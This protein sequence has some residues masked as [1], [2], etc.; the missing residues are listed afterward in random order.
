MPSSQNR[1]RHTA[2]LCCTCIML[3]FKPA[4]VRTQETNIIPLHN[5]DTINLGT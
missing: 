5:A 4:V 3:S 1:M 2:G